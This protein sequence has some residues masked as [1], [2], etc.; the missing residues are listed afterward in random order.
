MNSKSAPPPSSSTKSYYLLLLA[1]CLVLVLGFLFSSSFVRGQ[2]LF[3]N[4]GP[5]GAQVSDIYKLPGS[6]FGI[7]NDL[8]WIGAYNGNYSANVTGTLLWLLGPILF[9]KF[10]APSGLFIL[11]VCA[12]VFFK[13]LGFRG[14]ACVLGGLAAALNMN[15]FSNACWGLPTRALSLAATFLALTAIKSSEKGFPWVKSILAGLAIGLSISE[16]ADN[17]AIFSLFVAAYALFQ[18]LLSPG[19]RTVNAVKGGVKIVVMAVFAAVLAAQ[20]LNVFVNTSVKGIVG[21]QQDNMSKEQ[22]WD[23]ATQ[24]S[25]P[26]KETLRVIIPGL[27]GYRM[28]TGEGGAYW[29]RVGEQPGWEIHKQGFPRYSGAGEYAG[30]L[31]VLIAIWAVSQSFRKQGNAFKPDERRTIWM[32]TALAGV[33]L[34]LAW[35]RH[36]PFYRFVYALPYFSTIRNPM[37]FMHPFHMILMILF[38]YGLEGMGRLYLE[39]AGNKTLSFGDQL[40]SW[41]AKASPFER[42]WTYGSVGFVLLSLAGYFI[43]F[44][45]RQDLARYLA[46]AGFSSTDAGRI[47]RFS[48]HEVGLY[49]LFL[50]LSVGAVYLIQCGVFAGR[51]AKWAAVFLGLIL[52]SDLARANAPW[53]IYYDYKEKYASN[54]AIELLRDKPYQHRITMPG[55]QLGQPFSLFQQIYHVEWLQHLFPFYNIQ[56]LDIPQEP[57]LPAEKQ[58]YLIALATNMTRLWQLTNTRYLGGLAGGFV[59][60][61]NQQLDPVKKRFRLKLSFNF[62]QKPGTDFIGLYLTNSGPF[63]L[64]EFTGALPRAKLYSKWQVNTNEEK[65]LSKLA[66]P[67]FDPTATVLVNDEIPPPQSSATN[68]TPGQVEFVRYAPKNIELK[69][70]AA[71]GSVLLLNDKYDPAW[72]VWVDGKPAPLLRCNYIMRGVQVPAGQHVVRFRFQPSNTIFFVSLSA[73]ILG[74][75]LCGYLF[76]VERWAPSRH[77]QE[78]SNTLK[79]GKDSPTPSPR[80]RGPG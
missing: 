2:A 30:V 25:L 43:Y 76:A 78:S 31:V 10:Y 59:D 68:G 15:F 11:G 7:W 57:R 13:S 32:W 40:K 9:N 73:V 64:I 53:I 72:H 20:T 35:G 71:S 62:Y 46:T 1:G 5:L 69:A 58:A 47:A 38:A 29:G 74:L 24:W 36:A 75:L 26:P 41:W 61:L 54:P 65:T 42:K 63:A 37:K 49:F 23:W 34:V 14:W 44:S 55:F 27:F 67:A 50:L 18:A 21:T 51:K 16:G 17:G 77:R 22:K 52:V 66:D 79:S 60:S 33:A 4:D 80:G 19:S 28:D 45:A 3:A 12:A 56:S 8:Q 48:A 70:D 39:K 6:F